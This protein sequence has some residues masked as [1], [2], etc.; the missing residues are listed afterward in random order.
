MSADQRDG[1]AIG[2]YDCFVFGKGRMGPTGSRDDW[3]SGI[4]RF[5]E[6]DPARLTLPVG[7]ALDHVSKA[8]PD[9]SISKRASSYFDGEMWRQMLPA[10][11]IQYV[12]GFM[13]CHADD[14]KLP[15]ETVIARYEKV[16]SDWYGISVTEV[17][18]INPDRV[19]A[20]MGDVI[21]S[22][23]AGKKPD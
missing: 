10:S 18:E 9:T 3:S 6:S 13:S 21:S 1:F 16:M 5:Y 15:P 17:D 2:Y 20:K 8:H 14:M 23:L 4:T 7:Q 19:T 11:R 12:Q 22:L